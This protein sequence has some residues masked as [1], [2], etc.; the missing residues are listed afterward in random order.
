V[1]RGSVRNKI[2]NNLVTYL[3]PEEY[4]NF[5]GKKISREDAELFKQQYPDAYIII[6]KALFPNKKD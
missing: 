4:E 3:T 5:S 2:E 1:D 6:C